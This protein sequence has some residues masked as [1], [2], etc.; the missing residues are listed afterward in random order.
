[1]NVISSNRL[2]AY[3]GKNAIHRKGKECSRRR[4]KRKNNKKNL[5]N[6]LT[7]KLLQSSTKSI[8]LWTQELPCKQSRRVSYVQNNLAVQLRCVEGIFVIEWL[9]FVLHFVPSIF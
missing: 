1:M 6:R 4:S 8:L 7:N 2:H 9:L 5:Y 3:I